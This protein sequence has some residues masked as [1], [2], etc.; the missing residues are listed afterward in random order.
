MN[1]FKHW[2][3]IGMFLAMPLVANGYVTLNNHTWATDE[4]VTAATLELY[5]DDNLNTLD[6]GLDSL[7]SKLVAKTAFGD[8]ADAWLARTALAADSTDITNGG[9][10]ATDLSPVLDLTGKTLYAINLMAHTSDGA[11][12]SYVGINGGGAAGNAARGAYI[13]V[14]GNEF[15]SVAGGIRI[16]GGYPSASVSDVCI[17]GSGGYTTIGG[18][19]AGTTT[20]D[21]QSDLIRIRT[22]KSP[23]SSGSGNQGE[24]CWDDSCIYVCTATNTWKRAAL[25]GGY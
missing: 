19:S 1:N 22:A 11:D 17:Q 10:S 3:I 20:L 14:F 4:L 7:N 16:Y 2:L 23:T 18:S 5:I 12:N 9:L 21:I 6:D 13:Q 25:T 24:I 8:S 15:S